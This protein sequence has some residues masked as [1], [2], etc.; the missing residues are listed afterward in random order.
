[1]EL[2]QLNYNRKM[3]LQDVVQTSEQAGFPVHFLPP[4]NSEHLKKF[5]YYKFILCLVNFVMFMFI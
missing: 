4:E 5:F 3:F 1:M 2:S